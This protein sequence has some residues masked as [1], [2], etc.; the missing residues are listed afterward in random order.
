MHLPTHPSCP[1]DI[2]PAWAG[3]LRP[4]T[5]HGTRGS[6]RP[7]G[8]S[9]ADCNLGNLGVWPGPHAHGHHPPIWALPAASRRVE[10]RDPLLLCLDTFWMPFV[11]LFPAPRESLPPRALPCPC[12]DPSRICLSPRPVPPPPHLPTSIIK[13]SLSTTPFLIPKS[14]LLS[15]SLEA[16]NPHHQNPFTFFTQ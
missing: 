5:A 9:D 2:C 3:R 14:R 15:T 1:S 13:Y 7:L 4:R 12:E 8:Y 6:D 16:F 11:T 10:P